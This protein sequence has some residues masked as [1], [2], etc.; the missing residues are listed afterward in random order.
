MAAAEALHSDDVAGCSFIGANDF[1][2]VGRRQDNPSPPRQSPGPSS[3]GGL[4][5]PTH[6]GSPR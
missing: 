2:P 5:P 6:A 4:N 1:S 3:G